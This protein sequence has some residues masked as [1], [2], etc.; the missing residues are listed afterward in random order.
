MKKSQ[1]FSFLDCVLH[2][3]PEVLPPPPPSPFANLLDLLQGRI[4]SKHL[5]LPVWLCTTHNI[6]HA[7]QTHAHMYAHVR[8]CTRAETQ[9]HAWMDA[10][11]M[12]SY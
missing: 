3:L 8:T 4:Q 12:F 5:P 6:M 1:D 2:M 9:T 10:H 11:K 7:D